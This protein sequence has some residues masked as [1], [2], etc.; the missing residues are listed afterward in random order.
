MKKSLVFFTYPSPTVFQL[1]LRAAIIATVCWVLPSKS[2]GQCLAS[3]TQ[4]LPTFSGYQPSQV[5]IDNGLIDPNGCP[6]VGQPEMNPDC[7]QAIP[8]F[9]AKSARAGTLHRLIRPTGGG[10]PCS[11]CDPNPGDHCFRCPQTYMEEIKRLVEF[12]ATYIGAYGFWNTDYRQFIPGHTWYEAMKQVVGDINGAFDCAGLKRPIINV[13][14]LS[15][16]KEK[17]GGPTSICIPKWVIDAFADDPEFD[18]NDYQVNNNPEEYRRFHFDNVRKV[19][20]DGTLGDVW[21]VTRIEARMWIYYMAVTVIEFGFTEIA[22]GVSDWIDNDISNNYAYTRSLFDK[23][24]AHADAKGQLLLMVVE[25]LTQSGTNNCDGRDYTYEENGQLHMLFDYDIVP[26]RFRELDDPMTDCCANAQAPQDV[27][28]DWSPNGD[29]PCAGSAFPAYL[30]YECAVNILRTDITGGHNYVVSPQ[31]CQYTEIPYSVHFDFGPG[32]TDN[33]GENPGDI[34]YGWAGGVYCF[35]DMYWFIQQLDPECAGYL[36]EKWICAVDE[37]SG[38]IGS[39]QL[40]WSYKTPNPD[41]NYTPANPNVPVLYHLSDIPEIFSHVESAMHNCIDAPQEDY[42]GRLENAD[43]YRQTSFCWKED[44][45]YKGES[46]SSNFLFG[47]EFSLFFL[48][49]TGAAVSVGNIYVD[50]SLS[51]SINITR[52]FEE[53]YGAVFSPGVDFLLLVEDPRGTYCSIDGLVTHSFRFVDP[54][55][56]TTDPEG[57]SK[58]RFCLDDSILLEGD[59]SNGPRTSCLEVSQRALGGTSYTPLAS[60][61][62]DDLKFPFDLNDFL[63]DNSI[64]LEKENYYKVSVEFT[65]ICVTDREVSTEFFILGDLRSRYIFEDEQGNPREEFCHSEEVF[66]NGNASDYESRYWLEA[67]RAPIGSSNFTGLASGWTEGEIETIS[68]SQWMASKGV[69]LEGGYIYQLKL[70]IQNDCEAWVEYTRAFILNQC[71]EPPANLWCSTVV[72]D[73]YLRWDDVSPTSTYLLYIDPTTGNCCGNDDFVSP[74]GILVVGN[75]YNTNNIRPKCYEWR[76]KSLCGDLS[77]DASAPKCMDPFTSCLQFGKS[78]G[79]QQATQL[80]DELP[81]QL[82]V[83]PNPVNDYLNIKLELPNPTSLRIELLDIKGRVLQYYVESRR[84]DG[85]YQQPMALDR[86]TGNGVYILRVQTEQTILT[87]KI[88]VTRS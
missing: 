20:S 83:S 69:P 9:L 29:S 43:G 44:V 16:V 4:D 33:C 74:Q 53:E 46:V 75:Q 7:Q 17:A 42:C 1:L 88:I 38:G 5:L 61:C 72:N 66:I 68:F 87:K 77:S 81:A 70:G 2:L 41:P 78:N 25:N 47:Y 73:V 27:I 80:L 45:F 56:Q 8:D 37:Y 64:V 22:W 62:Y 76:V 35:D 30:D 49:P 34:Q 12:E 65:D 36:I 24:R 15:A 10:V 39:V 59:F 3:D 85:V 19:N 55:I 57:V 50:N 79:I 58:D 14:L 32:L 48:D 67:G 31:G 82:S 26:A 84:V 18:I 23:I 21:D 40:P 51:P 52:L 54:S 28:D 60:A 11:D 71:C 63:A 6:M 13:G 86:Q